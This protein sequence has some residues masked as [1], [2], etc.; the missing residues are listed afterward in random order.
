[1][2]PRG[3]KNQNPGNIRSGTADWEG[4]SPTQ[5]DPEFV[6]FQGP[7]WGIRAIAKILLTY[8]ADGLNTVQQIINR[9]APPSENDTDAY[10]QA[11]AEAC[12]VGAN[13]PINVTQ[14]LPSLIPAIIKHENGEQPYTTAQIEAGIALAS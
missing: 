11:V 7:Q 9:W 2:I 4:M 12:G 14:M 1:M 13:T 3:I 6:Q 10:V 5:D 8:E